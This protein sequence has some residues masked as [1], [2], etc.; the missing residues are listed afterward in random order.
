LARLEWPL[1]ETLADIEDWRR[2]IDA[3]A[4]S[5]AQP[6]ENSRLEHKGPDA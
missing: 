5:E 3:H 4:R 1:I 2:I 6:V